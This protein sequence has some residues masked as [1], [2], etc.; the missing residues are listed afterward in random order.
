MPATMGGPLPVRWTQAPKAAEAA[1]KAQLCADKAKE[2]SNEPKKEFELT[3]EFCG[4]KSSRNMMW[5][6]LMQVRCRARS[7]LSRFFVSLE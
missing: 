6:M 5:V 3:I 7:E 2:A 1:R 4:D